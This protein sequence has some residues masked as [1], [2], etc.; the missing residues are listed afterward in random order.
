LGVKLQALEN[1]IWHASLQDNG[2]HQR[3]ISLRTGDRLIAEAVAAAL[4]ELSTSATTTVTPS[5]AKVFQDWLEEKIPEVGSATIDFYRQT[6]N[7]FLQFLGEKASAEISAVERADIISYRALLAKRLGAKT[8]NHR[9]KSLRSIFEFAVR[10]RHIIENPVSDVKAVRNNEPRV[11][12][13][14]TMEEIRKLLEKAD[15]EWQTLIRLGL[16]TGQRLG[17]LVRLTWGDID[18][19]RQLITLISAKTRRRLIIPIEQPLLEHLRRY[20][21][22]R[23]L[24]PEMPVH[25]K[26]FKILQKAHGRVA[27]LSNHFADLLAECGLRTKKPH[28]ITV[29]YG[30]S[31][32]RQANELCFHSFRHT[33][34]SMLK[35]ANVPQAVVMEL[36]GHYSEQVSAQYTHVG[37]EALKKAAASLPAV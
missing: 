17:D 15:P 13:P 16:Y 7:D 34:V 36:I 33:C 4:V 27:T 6:M 26:A 20:L 18:F 12:R 29:G 8:V 23:V 11:R 9:T 5:V 24:I 14:F 25:P 37:L 2:G 32:R 10:R 30:R 21:N 28:H 35:E 22:S 31:G 19:D 1:G 3:L